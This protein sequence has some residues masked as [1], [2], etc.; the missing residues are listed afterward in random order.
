[1]RRH[2]KM[3]SRDGTFRRGWAESGAGFCRD[4][5]AR[6]DQRQPGRAFPAA[7]H[8]VCVAR[9]GRLLDRRSREEVGGDGEYPEGA[10]VARAPPTRGAAGPASA[11]DGGRHDRGNGR[12][13]GQLLLK[14]EGTKQRNKEGTEKACGRD[15]LFLLGVDSILA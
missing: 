1:M 13:G 7:A 15:C 4:G 6:N 10:L 8:R 2:A 9:D 11:A 12:S 5:A 3:T 14:N